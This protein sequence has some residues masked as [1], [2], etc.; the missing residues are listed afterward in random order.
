VRLAALDPADRAPVRAVAPARVRLHHVLAP[1]PLTLHPS[2]PRDP[3]RRLVD[4]AHA[5][6][7]DAS[8]SN[9]VSQACGWPS[10]LWAQWAVRRL[11]RR[12]GATRPKIERVSGFSRVTLRRMVAAV[13]AGKEWRRVRLGPCPHG[14]SLSWG[15]PPS[16]ARGLSRP[17]LGTRS[18]PPGI[19]ARGARGNG[20]RSL[21]DYGSGSPPTGR[22]LY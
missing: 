5:A 10:R 2:P 22:I 18:G 16:L 8:A 17:A 7:V 9:D 1:R 12:R 14:R 21:A 19:P 13:A 11:S 3:E 15:T 6:R 4:R 20:H